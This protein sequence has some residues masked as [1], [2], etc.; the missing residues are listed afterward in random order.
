MKL[1]RAGGYEAT[2]TKWHWDV[3]SKR[4]LK[5]ER[6]FLSEAAAA[7]FD[8]RFEDIIRGKL[9][10]SFGSFFGLDESP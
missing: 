10:R 7:N 2:N 5:R 3:G 8:P 9:M 6:N 1:L 4:R